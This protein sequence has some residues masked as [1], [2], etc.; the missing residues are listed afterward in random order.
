MPKAKRTRVDLIEEVYTPGEISAISG[1][2]GDLLR[3]WRRRG[4]SPGVGEPGEHLRLTGYE[5]GRVLIFGQL[6]AADI[7]LRGMH[8]AAQMAS[9]PLDQHLIELC[10]GDHPHVETFRA[11]RVA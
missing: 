7:G 1:V 3:D 5:I 11:Q 9:F 4:V 10:L 6:S 2:S 8:A